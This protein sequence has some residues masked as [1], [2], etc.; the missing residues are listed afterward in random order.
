MPDM[1][2]HLLS[3]PPLDESIREMREKGVVIRRALSFE[4]APVRAFVEDHFGA[5]WAD[6][7]SVGYGNKPSSVFVALRDG[8][9]VGFGAYECTNRGFFGPTGVAESE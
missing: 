9:I 8:A 5:G 1:L 6:E 2:V 7:I 4:I 3:L